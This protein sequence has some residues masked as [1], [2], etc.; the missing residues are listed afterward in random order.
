MITIKNFFVGFL[1]SFI[2]SIP[3]GYLNV[4]GYEI[5]SKD[6]IYPTIYYLCGVVVI[7]FFVIFLTL[8]FAKKLMENKKLLQFI[9][10]FS[11]LFMFAL[12]YVFY[13][14][15]ISEST[16]TDLFGNYRGNY[17]V[18]GILLS[19]LNFIQIPFWLSWNLYLLNG[20]YIEISKKR[21]FFYVVGTVIGTFAGMLVLILS[22]HYLTNQTD[23]LEKYLMKVIIPLV[24]AGLGIFQ[25]IKYY[26]K[27]VK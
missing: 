18:T 9:D 4:V 16:N 22:L 5:Y 12:A 25:A 8:I 3:L 1:I 23:F 21:N 20:N 26:R 6:G 7:E 10:A 24:F 17:F 15:A 19:C 27:Y 14:S 2:G 11:V 13:A